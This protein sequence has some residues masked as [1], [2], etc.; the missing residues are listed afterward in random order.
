MMGPAILG[1]AALQINIVVN[2]NLASSI[3]DASGHV[4]DGPVS[5]LGYA[6][7]FLQLPVGI[8]GVAIAS[9]TLPSISRSAGLRQMDEFGATIARSLGMILLLTIPS[10]VGLAVMGESMIA[11][12]Y[13]GSKFTAYD[14][15]Q[16][17]VALTCFSAGLAGYAAIKD[18]GA[19][20]LRARR[21]AHADARRAW[22]RLR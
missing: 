3:T 12:I 5:W 13:Q 17:A 20:V 2:S 1:N 18:P 11:A 16:T 8:F 7:R 10:S 4:I 6:F 19:G 15:H 9:A 21:R 14:T 22:R